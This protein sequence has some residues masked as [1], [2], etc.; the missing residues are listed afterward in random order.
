[1][2]IANILG[3]VEGEKKLRL[4]L[5]GVEIRKFQLKFLKLNNNL[6]EIKN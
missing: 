2:F 3:I 6:D 5:V 4:I 1:M